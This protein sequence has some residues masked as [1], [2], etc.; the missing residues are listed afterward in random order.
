MEERI[1]GYGGVGRVEDREGERGREEG[2][3]ME[4][5]GNGDGDDHEREGNGK[6]FFVF[7]VW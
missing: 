2:K 4:M 1:E 5:D 6:G 3:V 7:A